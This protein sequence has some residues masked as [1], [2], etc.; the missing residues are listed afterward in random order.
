M[1]VLSS[2]LSVCVYVNVCVC[3]SL[4]RNWCNSVGILYAMMSHKSD[5][6]LVIFDLEV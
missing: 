6:I 4:T 1:K 2:V 5:Q 3:V